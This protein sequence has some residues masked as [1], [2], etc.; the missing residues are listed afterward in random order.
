MSDDIDAPY[1]TAGAEAQRWR[2]EIQAAH[3]KLKN[4]ESAFDAQG[5]IGYIND[6]NREL[7]NAESRAR[8]WQIVS[9]RRPR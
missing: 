7:H 4:A 8:V 3:A 9:S 2:A 5:L 6:C 1:K